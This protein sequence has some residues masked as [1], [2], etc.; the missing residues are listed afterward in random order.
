MD[1][2]KMLSAQG[3][4]KPIIDC[5]TIARGVCSFD[6]AQRVA[7]LSDKCLYSDSV[8]ADIKCPQNWWFCSLGSPLD[9]SA[10]DTNGSARAM[11][12]RGRV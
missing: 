10:R 1:H 11:H 5:R 12:K 2:A 3:D 8:S 9:E 6:G 7:W 4:D